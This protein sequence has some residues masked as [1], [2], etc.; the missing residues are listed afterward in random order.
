MTDKEKI[1]RKISS[2]KWY[3]S[4]KEQACEK[5]KAYHTANAELTKASKAM[6]YAANKDQCCKNSR[7]YYAANSDQNKAAHHTWAIKH[8]RR[9]AEIQTVCRTKRTEL[10]AG[11]KRPSKCSVCKRVGRICF[12]HDHSTGEF[13]GWLCTQCN[14]ALGHAKD[15]PKLLRKLAEYLECAKLARTK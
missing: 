4:H 9:I 8:P 7:A 1:S 15:S 14:T 2:A 12:D 13:R 10:K 11:S 6:W 5:S 3:A